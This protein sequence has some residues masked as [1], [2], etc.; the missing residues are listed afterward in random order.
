MSS[1][2]LRSTPLSHEANLSRRS[3]SSIV[4]PSPAPTE[5]SGFW[6]GSTSSE[7]VMTACDSISSADSLRNRSTLSSDHQPKAKFSTD[8]LLTVR[9]EDL[10]AKVRHRSE[11]AGR[12]ASG[13]RSPIPDNLSRPSIR[14]RA[15]RRS[16]S[17]LSLPRGPSRR[18]TGR[19][20]WAY[21]C[22]Q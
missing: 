18:R 10:L 19:G 21:Y 8:E 13:E 14:P 15:R 11:R 17:R 3:C 1:Y 2:N 9:R 22:Q 12:H 7:P 6:G 4:L 5:I 20:G 16:N